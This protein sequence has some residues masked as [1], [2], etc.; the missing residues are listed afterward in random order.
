MKV[1]DLVRRNTEG[2]KRLGFGIVLSV[3]PWGRSRPPMG[4]N[5]L[6]PSKKDVGYCSISYRGGQ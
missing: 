2:F 3:H 5:S 4:N 6:S 1:G